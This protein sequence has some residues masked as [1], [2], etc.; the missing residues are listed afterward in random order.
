MPSPAPPSQF[1]ATLLTLLITGLVLGLVWHFIYGQL[2]TT[3]QQETQAPGSTTDQVAEVP[4]VA[5]PP[6]P[7][8]TIPAA[9]LASAPST[10]SVPV[11]TIEPSHQLTLPEE[12]HEHRGLS[13][14][15]KM[16]LKQ[17]CSDVQPG[18][19]RLK[20]CYRERES[21]LSLPCQQQ[22]EEQAVIKRVAQQR[23]N[24]LC[25]G[26]VRK[27]CVGDKLGRGHIY[28]CLEDHY[29]ELSHDC[30]QA[31]DQLTTN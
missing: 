22:V 30:Y 17:L 11:R 29:R 4:E 7:V 19:G 24:V 28:Q 5:N 14:S 13:L 18:G 21:Q 23:V 8:S 27:F 1:R 12:A 3:L 2:T 25:V 20:R 10:E 26:D 9:P 31:L 6:P 15:C 16:E